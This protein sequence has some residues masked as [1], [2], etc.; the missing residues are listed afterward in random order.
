MSGRQHI[1]FQVEP[2]IH[3]Q[4]LEVDDITIEH[5]KEKIPKVVIVDTEGEE[6]SVALSYPDLNRVR[7]QTNV[8]IQFT[9][10]IY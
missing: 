6:I 4:T 9:A 2:H 5:G 10:Y 7:I 8:P 3:Q 1:L